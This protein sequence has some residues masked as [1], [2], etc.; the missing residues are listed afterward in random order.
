MELDI[1]VQDVRCSGDS[2]GYILINNIIADSGIETEIFKDGYSVVWVT[3]Q[4]VVLNTGLFPY[5]ILI[6]GVDPEKISENSIFAGGLEAGTYGA[7]IITS[8][9]VSSTGLSAAFFQPLDTIF[10]YASSVIPIEVAGNSTLEINDITINNPCSAPASIDVDYSGGL[11]PYSISYGLNRSVE[12]GNLASITGI[13]RDSSYNLIITDANGCSISSTGLIDISFSSMSVDFLSE[14]PPLVYDDHPEDFSFRIIG[15]NRPFE[16]AIWQADSLGNK[17]SIMGVVPSVGAEEYIISETESYV[18][19]NIATL[20]YPGYL[21]LEIID[22]NSC[23][24]DSQLLICNN[25]APLS[26]SLAALKDMKIDNSIQVE[27]EPILET[28]LIPYNLIITNP[29]IL[30]FI[31]D[32]NL[33]DSITTTLNT[34]QHTHTVCR[35]LKDRSGYE[36]G[37]I[38]LLLLGETSDDWYFTISINNGFNINQRPTVLTEN[39]YITIGGNDYLV[40]VGIDGDNT[41]IKIIRGLLLVSDY[42]TG[43]FKTGKNIGLSTFDSGSYTL[44]ETVICS[45]L[46]SHANIYIA[47]RTFALD[48]LNSSSINRT[49]DIY[50][51]ETPLVVPVSS[52]YISKVNNFLTVLNNFDILDNL[53]I[54]ATDNVIHTGKITSRI[55][56]G[57]PIQNDL[58]NISYKRWDPLTLE[59]KDIYY[60]NEITTD[61]TLN[62]LSDGVYTIKIS[63][64]EYNRI[65]I[66]NGVDYSN[67]YTAAT[68]YIVDSMVLTTGDLDYIYGDLLVPISPFV[69]QSGGSESGL[70]NDILGINVELVFTSGTQTVSISADATVEISEFTT[71]DN[72]IRIQPIPNNTTCIISGPDDYNYSFSEPTIF[73]NIPDGVYSVS[74]EIIE[75]TSKYLSQNNYQFFAV[76]GLEESVSLVFDNYSNTFI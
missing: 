5:P 26:V 13:Y 3:G 51:P 65:Q 54:R 27:L 75:L 73:I 41:T 53:F 1:V 32:L 40:V 19:Y 22:D 14:S 55:D 43:Q 68:G 58:Y 28:I 6:Q 8:G 74:G 36:E 42:A 62:G 38:D 7:R 30:A 24:Y 63:D 9:V 50:N 29:D 35:Y 11:S 71:Y 64:A 47:G 56:G 57:Y 72:S 46:Y 18:V 69:Y 37:L 70:F 17:E 12:T 49:I 21:I 48:F 25:S 4:T 10:Y 66:V 60:N 23:S 39:L 34:T 76:S 2:S 16:I 52:P 59:L 61:S 67:H 44:N 31:K 15:N 33:Y 45:Y 20:I